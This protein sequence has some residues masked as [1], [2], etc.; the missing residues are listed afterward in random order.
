MVNG[1]ELEMS[2]EPHDMG[3]RGKAKDIIRTQTPMTLDNAKTDKWVTSEAPNVK[4]VG[5]RW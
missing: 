4:A 5:V 3:N 1:E 2:I